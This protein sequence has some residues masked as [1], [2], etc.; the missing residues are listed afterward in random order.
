MFFLITY[1]LKIKIKN[2][3]ELKYFLNFN[4]NFLYI[5]IIHNN[6]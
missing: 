5:I 6:S 4:I 3:N 1:L 2:L